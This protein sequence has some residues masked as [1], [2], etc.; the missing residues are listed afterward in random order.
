MR[1]FIFTS[2]FL[3]V[4][5]AL[6]LTLFSLPVQAQAS[7]PACWI[8]KGFAPQ[9][10]V[11]RDFTVYNHVVFALTQRNSTT[12]VSRF[13]G[14]WSGIADISGFSGDAVGIGVSNN[15][16]VAGHQL[17][18]CPAVGTCARIQRIDQNQ[19]TPVSFTIEARNSSAKFVSSAVFKRFIRTTTSSFLIADRGV[20]LEEAGEFACGYSWCG[21]Q[22]LENAEFTASSADGVGV[23]LGTSDGKVYRLTAN[24]QLNLLATIENGVQ[25][26]AITRAEN[27]YMYAAL[28]TGRVYYSTNHGGT[29]KKIGDII[30][31]SGGYYDLISV[32]VPEKNSA[33]AVYTIENSTTYAFFNSSASADRYNETPHPKG[34]AKLAKDDKKIW[35]FSMFDGQLFAFNCSAT[36]IIP[37]L[38]EK[39]ENINITVLYGGNLSLFAAN[40]TG[41]PSGHEATLNWKLLKPVQRVPTDLFQGYFSANG[42]INGTNATRPG[43]YIFEVKAAYDSFPQLP[44]AIN[45]TLAILTQN[46]TRLRIEPDTVPIVPPTPVLT[47][48]SGATASTNVSN[49]TNATNVS[50]SG[51]AVAVQNQTTSTTTSAPAASQPKSIHPVSSQQPQAQQFDMG[52]IIG[53]ALLVVL[54]LAVFYLRRP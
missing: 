49:V 29:W 18:G 17:E 31:P 20:I 33:V 24:L 34:S 51:Q 1:F 52:Q 41:N 9:A 36:P 23:L 30:L 48:V 21:R 16:F 25:V 53:I 32:M 40:I 13:D 15:I 54:I 35:A 44:Y 3:F 4:F 7:Y 47:N 22:F 6:I 46:G 10:V 42:W 45:V 19:L 50:T 27:N 8:S 37:L 39:T 38:N 14:L 5:T 11:P 28:T 43:T 26:T 2:L 12:T